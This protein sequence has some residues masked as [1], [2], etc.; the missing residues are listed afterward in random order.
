MKEKIF[1][2][3]T[4]FKKKPSEAFNSYFS[5]FYDK[6]NK[7]KEEE[8]PIEEDDTIKELE[9][10]EEDLLKMKVIPETRFDLI[11][12]VCSKSSI[13][14]LLT[15]I[16]DESIVIEISKYINTKEKILLKLINNCLEKDVSKRINI[17]FILA[18]IY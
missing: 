6:G 17:S 14:E 11:Y 5:I 1:T 18:S 10:F 16:L 4:I 7:P 12:N 9:Q 2:H 15:T 8:E 13:V 3:N